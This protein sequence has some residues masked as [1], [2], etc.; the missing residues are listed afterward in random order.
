M[1]SKNEAF[2]NG[3]LDRG[4][5]V[6]TLTIT[7]YD[8]AL[9]AAKELLALY[10]LTLPV[11]IEIPLLSRD[12][13]RGKRQ[14]SMTV[15]TPTM[16]FKVAAGRTE[17]IPGTGSISMADQSDENFL[18]L[19]KLYVDTGNP[20]VVINPAVCDGSVF[21]A[22]KDPSKTMKPSGTLRETERRRMMSLLILSH[23]IRWKILGEEQR[24]S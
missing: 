23:E 6:A 15:W 24:T 7:T 3:L 19:L 10:L 5:L 1:L 9:A 16:A 12:Q 17:T 18:I 4:L 8:E 2:L 22:C 14:K 21:N 13:V 11:G 20:T